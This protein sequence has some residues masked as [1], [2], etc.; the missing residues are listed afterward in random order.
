MRTAEDT[1]FAIVAD[2]E[3]ATLNGAAQQIESIDKIIELNSRLKL[4]NT[5][6]YQLQREGIL[7]IESG[8]RAEGIEKYKKAIEAFDKDKRTLGKLSLLGEMRME[9][10]NAGMQ[11]EKFSFYKEKLKYYL[12]NGPVENTAVC[13]HGIAGYYLSKADYNNALNYYL[14]AAGAFKSFSKPSYC[15]GIYVTGW[16]Y[17]NW[18][19][20]KQAEYYLRMSDSLGREYG[21]MVYTVVSTRFLGLIE[22]KKNN[23]SS[24]LEKMNEALS[25]NEKYI[26]KFTPVREAVMLCEKSGILLEL[27]KPEEALKVL[28]RARVL[29]D[30]LGLILLH[31]EGNIEVDYYFGLYYDAV[32]D[33]INAEKNLLRAHLLATEFYADDLLLKYNKAIAGFYSANGHPEKS[34]LYAL[35]YIALNDSIHEQQNIYNIAEF[36]RQL[37]ANEKAREV[38]GLEEQ[39][40]N[41]RNFFIAGGVLLLLLSVFIFS[42]LRLSKKIEKKL[43]EKN[44]QVEAARAR[45]EQSEKFKQQFLANMSHEIRTPMNAVM[46]MTSLLI[47]KNPRTEQQH[48]LDGIK[49]SSDN[50]LHIINDI[51]DLSKIEAGKIE[52]E[53]IDF[54]ILD[55]VEQV[56]QILNHRAEEKG[57]HFITEVD[58]NIP[59]V[60]IGDP[61]RINQILMNLAGNAVKFTEK[62]S[63]MISV[64]SKSQSDSG[65]RLEFSV[66]DTGIG[67][68]QEKLAG[69]FESFTQAHSSDTRKF[70]GTGLGLSIS[71]QLAELMGG[72]ISVESEEGAGTTFLFEINLPVGSPER[73][74]AQRTAGEIDGNILNGLKILVAD[75]N[76]FNRIVTCDSLL[77]KAQVEITEAHNGKEAIDLLSREDF[78]VVLMDVQM[79]VMDGYEATRQIRDP[80]TAVRNHAVPVIALTASV[81][82]SDLDKCRAAGMND[83]VPKP[84][85]IFQLISA[86]A[87]AAGREIKFTAAAGVE[88]KVKNNGSVINLSYLEKFSD[89]DKE[90]MKK[91]TGMFLDTAPLLINNLNDALAKN[92]LKE[93][94][95]QVHSYKTKW[96]MMGMNE[97]KDL[98]LKIEKQCR[99]NTN[100]SAINENI[101]VLIKQIETAVKEVK[102]S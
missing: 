93:I 60:L 49:K 34:S 50:L 59:E 10:N 8:K 68:P 13:Y 85:K 58:S 82:R 69:V 71:R 19:N 64:K 45:A 77:S 1:L 4:I 48:Y 72:K 56:K 98:A 74:F 51:L 91:Y 57:L 66:T 3:N 94:A 101:R 11:E 76:E 84:F 40:K 22:K 79:P 92:D 78:D 52:L 20:I 90:R 95:T 61:V 37:K 27:K 29:R 46:G 30:S 67:I 86:I 89:G 39:K 42:R 43:E 97:S 17:Y 63:V 62:G 7:L 6:P 99:D 81:V 5:K 75:D 73:L 87:K 102:N 16:M 31:T 18:G 23:F 88:S 83:Y 70:G 100:G 80:Q 2:V 33:K 24:A 36:E 55:V 65:I 26:D 21:F 53:H 44:K 35:R 47:D 41:Q 96:I 32:G 14:K 28:E 15:S 25:L 12:E 54:S 9:F 38:Q